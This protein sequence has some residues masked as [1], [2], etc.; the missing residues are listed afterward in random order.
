MTHGGWQLARLQHQ[1]NKKVLRSILC[2]HPLQN[3]EA[4]K[5]AA[6]RRPLSRNLK[7]QTRLFHVV[8]F[9]RGRETRN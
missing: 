8:G 4:Q 2:L 6:V 9:S 1:G 3:L 5:D 7:T